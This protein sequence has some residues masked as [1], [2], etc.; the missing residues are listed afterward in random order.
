MG[1]DPNLKIKKNRIHIPSTVF[2]KLARAHAEPNKFTQVSCL[3]FNRLR[4]NIK[5]LDKNYYLETF[6]SY[7]ALL[8]SK[9]KLAR[10]QAGANCRAFI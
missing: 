1:T 8:F 5:I 7:T 9:L 10:H 4:Y 6:V 3:T 2:L